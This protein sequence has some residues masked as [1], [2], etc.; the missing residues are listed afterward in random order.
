MIVLFINIYPFSHSFMHKINLFLGYLSLLTIS[1]IWMPITYKLWWQI[2]WIILTI[3]VF[4]RPLADI[5]P[6]LSWLRKGLVLRKWLGII[7][8]AAALAHGVGFFIIN[9]IPVLD[10]FTSTY[11]NFTNLLGRGMIALIFMM[12]PFVTS[13]KRSMLW[14]KRKWKWIQRFSYLAFIATAV[15]VGLAKQ[16]IFPLIIAGVYLIVYI[17]AYKKIIL[18][19]TKK[20]A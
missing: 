13:N 2:S 8:G 18:W 20:S 1:V 19:N 14:L 6:R 10:I 9:Q 15:H 16:E 5:L 11:W 4:S 7:C 17:L 12:F 3:I